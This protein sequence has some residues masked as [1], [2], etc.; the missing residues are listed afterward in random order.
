MKRLLLFV[1]FIILSVVGC[2]KTE[3]VTVYRD[4]DILLDSSATVTVGRVLDGDTFEFGIGIDTIGVRILGIDAFE[5]KHGTHLDG[6]ALAAGISSD[7]AL[8]LGKIAKA[9]ADSLLTGKSVLLFRDPKQPA[10][11]AFGR[12]LRHVQYSE[13]SLKLDF[14]ALMLT[15]KLAL[16]DT[17]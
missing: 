4:V 6:Q 11:D 10:F 15:K 8:A 7:S 14:G 3:I 1:S 16:I 13:G 5:T 17:L 2:E 12:M 9:F